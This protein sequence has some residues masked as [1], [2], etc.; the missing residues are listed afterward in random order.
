[1]IDLNSVNVRTLPIETRADIVDVRVLCVRPIKRNRTHSFRCAIIHVP[2][3]YIEINSFRRSRHIIGPVY[4][5]MSLQAVLVI[6][7]DR[8]LSVMCI[9]T[10]LDELWL[11]RL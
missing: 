10:R 11:A 4:Y 5:H 9:I 6:P 7:L 8:S 3:K 2:K 1:M